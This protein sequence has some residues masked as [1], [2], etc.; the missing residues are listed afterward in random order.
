M[1]AIN[2]RLS[3]TYDAFQ[4]GELNPLSLIT[5][6]QEAIAANILVVEDK[7]SL[8]TTRFQLELAVGGTFRDMTQ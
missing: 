4:H 6:Q 1:T 2:K 7:L 3:R 8:A 5:I